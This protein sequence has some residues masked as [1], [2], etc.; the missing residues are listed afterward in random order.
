MVVA[1]CIAFAG[2]LA[3]TLLQGAKTFY[4]DSDRYWQ[5]G[6]T[7]T[8][9]GHF[10]LLNFDSAERG[11]ALP[12]ID[13][14]LQAIADNLTWSS[15]SAARLFNVLIF[16][17][18]GA[19]LAPRLAEI[20]WPRQRWGLMRRLTLVGILIVFWNGH[21]D[22]PLSDFPS[23]AMV[24]LALVAI[25][26]SDTPGWML[27]AGV[28]GGLA[29]DMRAAYILLGPILVVLVIWSWLDR[30][31]AEHAPIAR[32][33]L[34]AGLLVLGFVA[35]SAPQ[36]LSSHRHGFTW[37]IVPGASSSV[38]SL[39]LTPGMSHQRYDTYVGIGQAGPQ[40]YY[41]DQAGAR[42]LEK[43]KGDK[44]SGSVQYLGLI[45][46]HPI[47]MVSLL[48]RHVINGLDA[49]YSTPYVEHL[50]SGPGGWLPFAGF[51]LVFLALVRVLWPTARRRL[52]P[53]KWRY[54]VALLLC[55][56][57]SVPTPVETRYLLPA[58]LCGYILVLTPGWPSPIGPAGAGLRRFRTPAI[59]AGAC[60][61][62]MA[63]VWHVTSVAGS[64][65]Q[66][67]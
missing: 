50:E 41:E 32:R 15:S 48:A 7:F 16:A 52:G 39:Y 40:M 11:Y 49:R 63:V 28:A 43:Q 56:A 4:Y 26:R 62:F 9:N 58:Y 34:C 8:V 3:V 54:P 27:L 67:R 10:S 55:C 35:V 59:I 44:I 12:L 64:H 5:L 46:S 23:L 31:G 29:I 13:H 6:E 30:R 21:L 20:A 53:A 65:L 36:S 57:T 1:F 51:L 45:V 38:S 2:T 17:L 18:V 47:A 61:I 33:A 66:F 24:L 37:S 19:V 14:G 60:L 22:F 25:A 42:L